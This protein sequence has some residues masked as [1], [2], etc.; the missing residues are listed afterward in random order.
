MAHPEKWT[1]DWFYKQCAAPCLTHPGN[2]YRKPR[3][4]NMSDDDRSEFDRGYQEGL[5]CAYREINA[6]TNARI[7]RL[8][9]GKNQRFRDE[10]DRARVVLLNRIRAA[11]PVKHYPAMWK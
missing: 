5:A 4:T 9:P 3:K 10:I 7:D 8:E 6:W 1:F 11:L 2:T